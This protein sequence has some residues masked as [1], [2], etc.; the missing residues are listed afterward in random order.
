MSELFS[1]V[2]TSLR[3]G[4][5]RGGSDPEY[6][7]SLKTGAHI[8]RSLGETHT[9][10]D[11][12]ISK[13]GKWHLQGVERSPERILKSLDVV[14][15]SMHG[16]FGEDGGVQEILNMSGVKYIGT[17]RYSSAVAINRHLA[18]DHL[19]Q[20]GIKIPVHTLV[21]KGENILS[22][23]K[24]IWGSLIHPFAIKPGK[25]GSSFG[26]VVVENFDDLVQALD[27][28]SRNHETILVEEFIPGASVSCLVTE[29]LRGQD[30]YAFSPSI[31]LKS[32]QREVVENMAK[33]VHSGLNLSHLS[34]S[35]FIV[36]PRRGVYFLEVNT[37]PKFTQKSLAN[38]AVESVGLSTNDFL[39]HLIRLRLNE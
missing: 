34:Q 27:F 22:K 28:L 7:I 14:Y 31:Q 25:G 4:V 37:S 16:N 36:S 12:F 9:P 10:F 23:A 11:I 18:K 39:H 32:D 5:L 29:K 2:P 26:F 15:N 6:D 35:D 21:K 30:L 13:N 38:K 20:Y 33:A 1:T 8:L 24:E 19:F 17:D 3:I